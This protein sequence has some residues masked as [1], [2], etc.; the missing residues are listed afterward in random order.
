MQSLAAW[1]GVYPQG[2]LATRLAQDP[3]ADVDDEAAGFGKPN[4]LIRRYQA[5]L[6]MLPT[7][8]RLDAGDAFAF[9]GE[10]R[11]IVQ[12]ELAPG[13]G[14]AEVGQETEPVRGGITQLFVEE[15]GPCLLYTSRCV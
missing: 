9:E 15:H 1:A 12:S 8:K 4:E 13:D 14:M 3:C 11:L 6:W 2:S 10:D 7:D 5:S